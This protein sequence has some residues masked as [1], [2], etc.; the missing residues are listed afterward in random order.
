MLA[1]G[2]M[3]VLVVRFSRGGILGALDAVSAGL[4]RR[5]GAR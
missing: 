1:I 4:K 3:L 2:V 5:L